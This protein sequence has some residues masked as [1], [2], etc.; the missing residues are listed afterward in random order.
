[1]GLF[2]ASIGGKDGHETMKKPGKS[3]QLRCACLAGVSS[4]LLLGLLLLHFIPQAGS[5]TAQ[6]Q[7]PLRSVSEI[8][9]LGQDK[10]GQSIPVDLQ[11]IVTYFDPLWKVLFVQDSTGPVFISIP[12]GT[13]TKYPVFARVRLQAIAVVGPHSW[14]LTQPVVHLLGPGQAPKA[15]AYSI[16]DLNAA[17]SV[18]TF[19]STEGVLRP[20]DQA[21]D[22]VCYRIFDGRSM[23]W[24]ISPQPVSPAS[25]S[26]IGATVRLRG[27]CG[28]HPDTSGKLN[29]AQL[30]VNGLEEIEKTDNTP[31]QGFTSP[32]SPISSLRPADANQRF[33]H[34]VHIRGTVTWKSPQQVVLQDSSGSTS[35]KAL[36]TSALRPGDT[37]DV[38]GFPGAGELTP[39]MLSDAEVRLLPNAPNDY[40]APRDTTA[41][42]IVQSSLYGIK[43]R[44]KA[45]LIGHDDR[46]TE[47]IYYF[48]AGDEQFSG[49]LPENEGIQIAGLPNGTYVELTGV[50]AL[51]RAA[52]K[53]PESFQLLLESP[54]DIAVDRNGWFS[55]EHLL[56]VAGALVAFV[57]VVLIWVAMLR[58]TVR[59]QTEI[60]RAAMRERIATRLPVPAAL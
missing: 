7:R 8:Q 41:K 46:A 24:V 45:R 28:M 32:A 4:R 14:K 36:D 55:I 30:Y 26:L 1:M 15:P 35:M 3:A 53:P 18:S 31:V 25:Q 16:S 39:V 13:T 22:R 9:R 12:P 11:G 20:C 19:V 56:I 43:V 58:R 49:R 17:V 50:A 21:M 27:A 40:I 47:H 23:A 10:A 54:S 44:L 57:C 5:Q 37:V 48:T 38:V 2:K 6:A 60:I 33:V 52:A 51:R 29:G 42:Q 59:K 34:P